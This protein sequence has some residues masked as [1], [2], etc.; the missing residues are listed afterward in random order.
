MKKFHPFQLENSYFSVSDANLIEIPYFG[1]LTKLA[2][3]QVD[4]NTTDVL[5]LL[6]KGQQQNN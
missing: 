2:L 1:S 6:D 3:T 4:L 5:S